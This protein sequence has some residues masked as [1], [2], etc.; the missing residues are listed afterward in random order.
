MPELTVGQTRMLRFWGANMTAAF[1][2]SRSWPGFPST[3]TERA[4]LIE[5]GATVPPA[6]MTLWMYALAPAIFILTAA[7]AV[8]A[9]M[10]PGLTLLYPNPGDIQP[11]PFV[12]LLTAVVAA[13]IGL[14]FPLAM[15][16]GA[17]LALAWTGDAGRFVA[18]PGDAALYAKF[19]S[20]LWRVTLVMC[21][22]FIPG[23]W[24]WIVY[25]LQ[26]GPFVT[27]LKWVTALWIVGSGLALWRLRHR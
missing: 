20:Q 15:A 18:Q 17:R 5:L 26:A 13:A 23:C 25:D 8:V 4:R 12:L 6:A 9:I 24:L 11:L 2:A 10:V 16:L 1:A 27:A 22:L 19:R 21:G 7:L 3:D 14:G